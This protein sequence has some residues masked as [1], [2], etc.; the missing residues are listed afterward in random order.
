MLLYQNSEDTGRSIKFNDPSDSR[1]KFAK[2]SFPSRGGD[3][4]IKFPALSVEIDADQVVDLNETAITGPGG[5][6]YRIQSITSS[7]S[8]G[9][10]RITY[11]PTMPHAQNIEEV[12]VS[13]GKRRVGAIASGAVYEADGRLKYGM[14][15]FNHEAEEVFQA[16]TP[17]LEIVSFRETI[18]GTL[19]LKK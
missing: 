14:I 4:K 5:F 8:G 12:F 10:T 7:P 3:I 6:G 1:D 9:N 13:D 15:E 11:T 18:S 2:V 19:T 16:S 17:S